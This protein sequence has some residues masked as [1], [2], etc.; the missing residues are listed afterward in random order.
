MET[1]VCSPTEKTKIIKQD[2]ETRIVNVISEEIVR[3][4]LHVIACFK[5]EIRP[6]SKVKKIAYF[7]KGTLLT[8][9]TFADTDDEKVL[10]QIYKAEQKTRDMFSD[11]LFD[12]TVIFNC[13]EEAPVNFITDYLR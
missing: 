4:I 2:P 3:K 13:K 1:G 11:F 12:F 7:P 9:W 6:I 5:E 10:R 8:F